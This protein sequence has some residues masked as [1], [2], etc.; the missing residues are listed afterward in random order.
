MKAWIWAVIIAAL[1]IAAAVVVWRA[2]AARRSRMLQGR[3]GPEYD[4][5]LAE[6][7]SKRDAETELAARAARRN[8]LDIRP[9]PPGARE[10]YVMEWQGVQAQFV[11]DPDRAVREADLLIQ[12]VMGD[13]GYPT[14]EFEQRAA[15]V[16]V[17]HPD[18]VENYR[19][20]HRLARASAL[21]D[22][23]TEDLRQAMQHYRALFDELLEEGSEAPL[24][25]DPAP[26]EGRAPTTPEALRIQD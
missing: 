7:G 20:G 14:D 4:R 21:G 10:R 25:R 3:F 18:V 16:S 13:R 9:L 15:D 24:A 8:E 11:D 22:A 2:L 23:T 1:V 19:E 26:Q 5:A 12:S 6:A 17:D